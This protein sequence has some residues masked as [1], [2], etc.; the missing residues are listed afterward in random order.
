MEN[1]NTPKTLDVLMPKTKAITLSIGAFSVRPLTIRQI[2]A[3]AVAP[4]AEPGEIC[5]ALNEEGVQVVGRQQFGLLAILPNDVELVGKTVFK[6]VT[7]GVRCARRVGNCRVRCIFV[8]R[9]I[10]D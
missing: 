9:K 4:G 10:V 5:R 1:E 7:G 6:I 8:V 2:A 3:L